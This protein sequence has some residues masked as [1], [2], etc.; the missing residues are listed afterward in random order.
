MYHLDEKALAR[1]QQL[2]VCL[3]LSSNLV[4]Q[5]GRPFIAQSLLLQDSGDAASFLIAERL[6]LVLPFIHSEKLQDQQ[7]MLPEH[8]CINTCTL[9]AW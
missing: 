8:C 1:A 5:A 2:M 3:L 4:V 9:H 6:W 7:V